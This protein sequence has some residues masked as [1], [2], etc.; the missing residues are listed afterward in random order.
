MAMN[1]VA[2]G[3]ALKSA[4]GTVDPA[5]YVGDSAGFR[6]ALFEAQAQAIIDHIQTFGVISVSVTVASVSGVTTGL[7]VSGPGLG[8]GTGTIA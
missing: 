1:K 8:T 5:D 7:G 3:A 2:L 6:T 4:A